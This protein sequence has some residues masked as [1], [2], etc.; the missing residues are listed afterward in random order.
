VVENFD[1]LHPG[2][3]MITCAVVTEIPGMDDT[4][5]TADS[6]GT[7]RVPEVP[8]PKRSTRPTAAKH[9]LIQG[10]GMSIETT[11]TGMCFTVAIPIGIATGR[12]MQI[13]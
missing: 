3:T 10:V 6:K 4:Q 8:A 9:V 2:S 11:D 5:A 12:A 13:T 7:M 1:M